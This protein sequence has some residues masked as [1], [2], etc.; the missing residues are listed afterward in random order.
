MHHLLLDGW[1]MQLLLGEA[2]GA[3]QARLRARRA[4]PQ[5]P[6]PR[7]FQE[8]VAWLGAQDGAATEAYWR[9]TLGRLRGPHAPP[10][11]R[12]LTRDGHPHGP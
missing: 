11:R 3:Y 9:R 12:R 5:L 2:F 8:Y 1:S 7:P 6:A 10:R 4:G